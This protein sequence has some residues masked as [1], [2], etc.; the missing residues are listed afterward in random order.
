LLFAVSDIMVLLDMPP[1]RGLL[2]ATSLHTAPLPSGGW[3][4]DAEMRPC[5]SAKG[6]SGSVPEKK[7]EHGDIMQPNSTIDSVR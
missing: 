2:D 1:G 3:M 4:G 7:D 6:R 5:P